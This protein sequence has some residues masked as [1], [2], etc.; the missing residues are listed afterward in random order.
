MYPQKLPTDVESEAERLLYELLSENLPSGFVVMHSV[1]WLLR[2]RSKHDRDGEPAPADASR[3]MVAA[4][5]GV[6]TRNLRRRTQAHNVFIRARPQ[7]A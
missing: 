6:P 4:K 3:S 7:T 2:D 1:K 5:L